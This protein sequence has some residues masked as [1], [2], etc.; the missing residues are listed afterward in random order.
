MYS[1]KVIEDNFN[2]VISAIPEA[3]N[4]Y[5]YSPLAIE[6]E[7][8]YFANRLI[9]Q[10]ILLCKENTHVGV[11][12]FTLDE[13]GDFSYFKRPT[14]VFWNTFATKDDQFELYQI[15]L[16]DLEKKLELKT[17]SSLKLE[18]N[19][20]LFSGLYKFSPHI[21]YSYQANIDLTCSE[22][23]IKRGIRRSYRSLINWGIREMSFVR[24]DHENA[25]NVL[26]ESFRLFHIE[27]S[28]RETRSKMTWDLQFEMIKNKMCY[29]ELGYYQEKLVSG[30]LVLVGTDEAYYGVAVND[31]NL[32]YDKKPIGHA[33]MRRSISHAKSLGLKNFNLG[34]IGPDFISEKDEAIGKF[35]SGLSSEINLKS[36]FEVVLEKA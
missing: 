30:V 12:F 8:E 6:Y 1:L 32:M 22:E 17:I 16:S 31:R 3:G 10:A 11:M 7:K 24:L 5:L 9:P 27:V 25:D 18:Y 34:H 4:T 29:L 14:Q 20:F 21:R 35:K 33:I 26:F 19:S 15:L 28:G 2:E 23:V 13:E 36:Y